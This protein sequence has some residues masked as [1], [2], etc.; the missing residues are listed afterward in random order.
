M[1]PWCVVLVCSWRCLLADRHSLPFPWT[2]SLHRRWCPSA[3]HHPLTCLFL[4]ALTFPLY[5]PFPFL[6]LSLRRP[7]C[8]S[9]SPL[10]PFP[11][12]WSVVPTEPPDLPCFTSPHRV[13]AEEGECL[14]RWPGA[15]KRPSQAGGEV[16]LPNGGWWALGCPLAGSFP[17]RGHITT[18]RLQD[19][20]LS[21]S[22]DERNKNRLPSPS[23][24]CCAC[25]VPLATH[26]A[27][28]C[29][30]WRVLTVV[31]Y[32]RA[33]P[34]RGGCWAAQWVLWVEERERAGAV[35][36]SRM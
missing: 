4:L 30:L 33:A 24:L 7:W 34:H 9:L 19:P 35:R 16:P 27:H 20:A 36:G 11:F 17:R 15:S 23:C 32:E 1:T 8:I 2:L 14:H 12:P 13:H 6:G 22:F 25:G 29:G 10:L 26:G 28:G 31:G 21:L 5:F 18:F 3:S